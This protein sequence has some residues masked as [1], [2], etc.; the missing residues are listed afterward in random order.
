MTI[1]KEIYF[2]IINISHGP[3]T[4]KSGQPTRRRA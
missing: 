3:T 4:T 2:P 1:T